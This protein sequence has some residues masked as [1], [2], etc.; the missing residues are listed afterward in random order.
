MEEIDNWNV[1]AWYF[2]R[3]LQKIRNAFKNISYLSFL[4]EKEKVFFKVKFKNNTNFNVL[5]PDGLKSLE[6]K[7]FNRLREIITEHAGN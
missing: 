6:D 3:E 7:D 1:K 4:Q 5:I 2:S